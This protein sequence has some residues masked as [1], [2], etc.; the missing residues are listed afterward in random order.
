MAELTRRSLLALGALAALAY[1]R[2]RRRTSL[3]D[4]YGTDPWSPS[5]TWGRHS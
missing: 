5:Q 3:R 4:W 1:G 2:P